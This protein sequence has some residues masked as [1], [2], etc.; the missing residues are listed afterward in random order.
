MLGWEFPPY[1]HGGLGVASLGLAQALV[2]QDVEVI[3]VLPK[4]LDISHDS[5]KLVFANVPNVKI[6]SVD[7]A[8]TPYLVSHEYARLRS[9]TGSL[10]YGGSLFE[11]MARYAELIGDIAREAEFDV[12]HAHDWLSYLAGI[13][14]K[15]VSGKPLILHVHA[16]SF[17][18]SGRG[19][20]N[21]QQYEVE[22]H[23]MNIADVVVTV[24]EFTK[25][26]IVNHYGVDPR[27]VQVVHNGIETASLDDREDDL[28]ALKASG[29]KIVL[30]HGRLTIQKGPD[31]FIRAAKRVLEYNPNVLFI[32][33]G[34]GDMEHQIIRLAAELGISEHVL[35][36]G[37]LWDEERDRM[38]RAAD[39]Y[40]MPSVSE[41]FG[42]TPL[43]ALIKGDTPVII[44]K[45]SGVSEV[46]KHALTVDFWDIDE[47]A[48]KI[49]AVLGNG[50]L[51]KE[52][53]TNGRKEAFGI[54]W[55]KAASKVVEIYNDIVNFFKK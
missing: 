4:K 21:P 6:K 13:E 22:R 54:T 44:S 25:D 37:A 12:I 20:V 41:P 23:A 52:L 24:S 16:T 11:E 42:L 45:Q 29:K 30:Y 43:E 31:Y 36:A 55:H 50:A 35:F 34:E 1:H 3:F 46:L 14:A 49:I 5:I 48:N 18:Q 53:S 33:S 19:P 15:H 40:V 28:F 38:Y 32:I 7:T 27:K 8:L 51:S 26:T 10:V 47:M 39:L 17:D 9:L 2:E